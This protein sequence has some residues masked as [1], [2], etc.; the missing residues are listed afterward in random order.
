M[1][2]LQD[3][4]GDIVCEALCPDV[5][6]VKTPEDCANFRCL[7]DNTKDCNYSEAI[8]NRIMETIKL[9]RRPK[10]NPTKEKK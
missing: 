3:D 1:A 2:S 6:K 8:T 5:D 9:H 10:Y 4:I 7:H